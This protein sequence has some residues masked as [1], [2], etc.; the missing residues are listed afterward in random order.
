MQ[1]VVFFI[2]LFAFFYLFIFTGARGAGSRRSHGG[3]DWDRFHQTTLST[4]SFEARLLL[5]LME[6]KS[7]AAP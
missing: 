2:S 7:P 3:A 5:R 6:I 4:G 1:E